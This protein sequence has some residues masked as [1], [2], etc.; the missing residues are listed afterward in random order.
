MPISTTLRQLSTHRLRDAADVEWVYWN[1]QLES[2]GDS[3]Y[4]LLCN[5]SAYSREALPY[6]TCTPETRAAV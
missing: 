1:D 4:G 2:L 3:Q 5:Y 6:K